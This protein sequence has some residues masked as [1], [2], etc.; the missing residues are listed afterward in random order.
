MSKSITIEQILEQFEQALKELII[1]Q[2]QEAYVKG[3]TDCELSKKPD[4]NKGDMIN[5]HA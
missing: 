2:R 3:Y 4:Y 5:E 1:E